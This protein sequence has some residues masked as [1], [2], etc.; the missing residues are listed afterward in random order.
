MVQELLPEL[1]VKHRKLNPVF[2]IG[3]GRSGTSILIK[4]IRK[5]LK[6]NFGTESQFIL[7]YY[8][9]LE[10]YGD[11]NRR[12]N[13]INL[14]EDIVQERYFKRIKKRFNF[15]LDKEKVLSSLKFPSYSGLLQAIFLQFAQYHGMERWGDKTP[16][17]IFGLD[18]ILRLFPDAQF[19]HIVRDGRDVAL[20][21]FKTHF[22]PKNVHCAAEEWKKRINLAQN[23]FA[24]LKDD[25]KF[26]L[27]YEDLLQNPVLIFQQLIDFLGIDD[28]DK[29]LIRFIAK[30]IVCDLKRGNFNKW[31]TA[32]S[33]SQI[34]RFERVAHRELTAYHYPLIFSHFTKPSLIETYYWRLHSKFKR[35]LVPGTIED[36]LYR[37]RLRV[38][39]RLLPLRKKLQFVAGAHRK[40]SFN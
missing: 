23:F 20:S 18:K 2:V 35:L 4:L 32:L 40:V 19:I 33:K 5:Y 28:Q 31:H 6:I 14:L 22:G 13:L 15:D 37:I 9:A 11:L 27:R 21:E 30:N 7:R 24:T 39:S 29:S 34:Y 12:E 1:Q 38:K 3:H 25:Q 16:E 10:Q 17:Y 36:N 8:D 26:E